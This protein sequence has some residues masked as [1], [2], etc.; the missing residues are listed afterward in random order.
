VRQVLGALAL[1]TGVVT[2]SCGGVAPTDDASVDTV[3]P[4]DPA[5]V[6][7]SSTS[8]TAAQQVN[9]TATSTAPVETTS[10]STTTVLEIDNPNGRDDDHCRLLDAR[11][12]R[13]SP[14]VGFPRIEDLRTAGR[15]NFELAVI[16]FDDLPAE[17]DLFD[18]AMAQAG[19][20]SDWLTEVSQGRLEADW[21]IAPEVVRMPFASIDLPVS[22]RG[23]E[24]VAQA[25]EASEVL[26]RELD[27][28]IDF[29]ESDLLVV[30]PPRA[31]Q[32]IDTD[33][34]FINI[35]PESDE[36]VVPRL[37]ASGAFF[38]EPGPYD[39]DPTDVDGDRLWSFWA[40]ELMHA[41]GLAGHAPDSLEFGSA[42]DPRTDVHLGSTQDA[43]SKTLSTWDLFLLGW[44]ADEEVICLDASDLPLEVQLEAVEARSSSRPISAMIRLSDTELLVVESKRAVGLG[45]DLAP[46]AGG[47][48]AYRVDTT[49]DNNRA[50]DTW[51]GQLGERFAWFLEPENV[52]GGDRFESGVNPFIREGGS[53]S[54]NGVRVAVV[55]SSGR[56]IVSLESN[57]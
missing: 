8:T 37:F 57:L 36:G 56:D 49:I 35:S 32:A 41:F 20:L 21:E 55:D 40:H 38:Y 22:K 11:A 26:V 39:G 43:L 27:P 54:S 34:T 13:Y 19:R 2:A 16:D 28:F 6:V 51:D 31:I 3:N 47:V 25:L 48:I 9:T 5:P 44:L 30:V 15:L 10:S 23:P 24:Y 14:S 1:V 52:D 45:T 17:P 12:E 46:S 4:T 33:I 7:A 53:A 50:A 42:P 29:S 18:D